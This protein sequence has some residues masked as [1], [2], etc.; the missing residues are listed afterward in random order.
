[1]FGAILSGAAFGDNLAPVSDTTIVSATTQETD[2]PGVVRSRFKYAITAAI[3]A[4]LL[5]TF[6]GGNGEEI[7]LAN[8]A[9]VENVSPLGLILLVPF[10][11]VI[12]LAMRHHHIIV[13]ITIGLVAAVPIILLS[14]LGT[15][16]D[17]V[18]INASAGTLDGALT[19]G[20][21]GYVDMAVL[22]LLI[23]A[24]SH[25]MR[26]GG[27]FDKIKEIA[28]RFIHDSARRAELVICSFVATLNVFITVNTA[29]EIA[30]A[31]MVSDIGKKLK[32]H[33]YRRANLLDAITSALGYIFPWGGG[34]LIGYVTLS[35]LTESYPALPVVSPTDVWMYVFHG[36]FLLFVM[37]GAA[38]T[39]IGHQKEK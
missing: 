1:M 15:L 17:I 36:W 9:M 18:H 24:A 19:D 29:A 16:Q 33:P 21:G 39:G 30:A 35:S 12:Y 2:I 38:A 22:T 11:L 8:T 10:A 31:P 7:Q 34:V 13:A 5:Y 20:I 27:A 6:L 26:M 23:L 28:F 4:L 3:P 37:F 25:I 32:I 14:G